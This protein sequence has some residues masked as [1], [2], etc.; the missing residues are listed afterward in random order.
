MTY[1]Q[2]EKLDHYKR[3]LEDMLETN[4]SLDS[5]YHSKEEIEVVK[6]IIKELKG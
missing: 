5:E 3:R 1:E 4:I 6:D 2:A